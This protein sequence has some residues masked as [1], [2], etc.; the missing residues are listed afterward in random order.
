MHAMRSDHDGDLEDS[1][2]WPIRQWNAPRRYRAAA[3]NIMPAE[4][5]L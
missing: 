4:M 3:S 5:W 1:S 2:R